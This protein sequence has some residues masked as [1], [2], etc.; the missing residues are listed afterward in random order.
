MNWLPDAVG[1]SACQSWHSLVIQ[2]ESFWGRR[3]HSATPEND[4]PA[5]R[6]LRRAAV[7]AQSVDKILEGAERSAT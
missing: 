4:A 1:E 3:F 6:T 7:N 5:W 2:A